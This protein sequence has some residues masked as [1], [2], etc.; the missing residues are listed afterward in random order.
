MGAGRRVLPTSPPDLY[1]LR[2]PLQSGWNLLPIG[3]NG[4][5]TAT[6]ETSICLLPTRIKDLYAHVLCNELSSGKVV[7]TRPV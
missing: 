5:G 7:D 1:R 3:Y 6:M 4:T 2:Q